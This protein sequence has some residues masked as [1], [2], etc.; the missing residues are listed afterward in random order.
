[1]RK[2]AISL[3]VLVIIIIVMAILAAT[4][5]ISLSNTSLI[6]QAQGAKENTNQASEKEA[7][8]LALAEWKIE[9]IRGTKTF[10]KFMKEKFGEEKVAK[11]SENEVTVSMESGKEYE[12]KSDGRIA[13]VLAIGSYVQYDIPYTDMYSNIEYTATTGWRYLGKDDVGNKLIVS[14]GIP[15]RLY[16]HYNE[17]TGSTKDGGKNAWWATKAEISATKDTLYKTSKDYDYNIE[18]GEPNKYAAY[19]LRY[20]F[21]EILFTYQEN[22]TSVSTANMGIFRK[23]GNIASGTNINL[24]FKANGV[25]VVDV[26]NLTLAELNRATNKVSGTTRT[27]SSISEGFKDLAGTALGLFDIQKLDEY[28]QNYWYWLASPNTNGR[29]HVYNVYSNRSYVYDYYIGIFGIRPVVT[30]SSDI[31]LVDTDSDGVFEI[32]K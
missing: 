20:K 5:I 3:V 25:D 6:E 30:L 18:E 23:V 4:V 24:N 16:Y 22:E 11:T 13:N 31:Q 2:N 10:E 21:D 28:A 7:L 19:G 15:A 1:M 8:S 9:E 17:N 14:T 26:H 32:V 27:D 29:G 12:V